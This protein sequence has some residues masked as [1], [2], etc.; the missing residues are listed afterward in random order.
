[1][2]LITPR[3]LTA[4]YTHPSKDPWTAVQLYQTALTYP[5]DWG[6]QRVATAINSDTEVPF[7]GVTR[8]E[9]RA[10]VDGDG[11][12]DAA[13][14]LEVAREHGWLTDG[15]TPTTRALAVLV[16]CGYVCGSLRT[17]TYV[18][19]WSPT[20]PRTEA[21][22]TDALTEVGCDATH[23]SR[24][25][26]TQADEYRP[27]RQA[28]VLGRALAVAGMP[29]GDKNATTVTGLPE[30]V[31]A[32]P[33]DLKATVARCTVLERGI[34]YPEK[35]TRRIQTDREPQYFADLATLL[36]EVTG[37]AV[38]ASPAGVTISAAAVDAL[39]VE[40]PTDESAESLD[41][42]AETAK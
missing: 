32:A 26:T 33:D 13:R 6:A 37:E 19:T 14:A 23:I 25:S 18:P 30:W 3:T 22:I 29:V 34:T 41:D 20:D 38:T 9:L 17:E 11:Q 8:G 1:M 35:A 31:T 10:W 40:R 16:I 36:R 27:T 28:S 24:A 7:E 2:R 12:P 21:T 5:D 15:W 42:T 39:G 4:T